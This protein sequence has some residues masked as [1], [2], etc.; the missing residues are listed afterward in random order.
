[1]M[2]RSRRPVR[3]V[4]AFAGAAAGWLPAAPVAALEQHYLS[5]QVGQ[6]TASISEVTFDEEETFVDAS[7][8]NG[9]PGTDENA[10]ALFASVDS[11]SGVLLTSGVT[12]DL[13]VAN[14]GRA[15]AQLEQRMPRS[16]SAT[17]SSGSGSTAPAWTRS[18][19]TAVATTRGP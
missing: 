4:L 17:A 6:S 10:R 19:R 5:A 18:S 16:S 1:M 14:M 8:Q 9:V 7:Y 2:Q 11:E 12:A 3:A 13:T 15:V